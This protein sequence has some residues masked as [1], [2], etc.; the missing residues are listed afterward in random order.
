MV[1]QTLSSCYP[2]MDVKMLYWWAIFCGP[3]DTQLWLSSYG[4]V[5]AL[6]VGYIL[7]SNRHSALVIQLYF[8]VQQTLSSCYLAMDV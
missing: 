6:L 8:V 4:Y 2:A 1:Q 3:T 7:W 5:D